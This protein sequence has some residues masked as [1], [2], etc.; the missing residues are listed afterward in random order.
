MEE[1]GKRMEGNA[2]TKC[3]G[4]EAISLR[5][6]RTLESCPFFYPRWQ[7][8]CKQPRVK[9]WHS[10][11]TRGKTEISKDCSIFR[12]LENS[13]YLFFS[14]LSNSI[15]I[16]FDRIVFVPSLPPYLLFSL[17]FLFLLEIF[18]SVQGIIHPQFAPFVRSSTNPL[19]PRLSSIPPPLRVILASTEKKEIMG[20]R[21]GWNREQGEERGGKGERSM[22]SR[23]TWKTIPRPL[24]RWKSPPG[25]SAA[26]HLLPDLPLEKSTRRRREWTLNMVMRE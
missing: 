22:Q 25:I 3:L 2:F 1:K 11:S 9:S 26:G 18:L 17:F 4:E 13:S 15:E 10:S 14:P 16:F 23:T 21:E 8:R 12:S 19:L 24:D 20:S 7:S 5:D 6:G